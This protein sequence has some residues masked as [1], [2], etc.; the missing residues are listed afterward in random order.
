MGLDEIKKRV[1]TEDSGEPEGL[2]ERLAEAKVASFDPWQER[3]NNKTKN[4]FAG[5]VNDG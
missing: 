1:L 5:V 3:K 2:R 4:Q